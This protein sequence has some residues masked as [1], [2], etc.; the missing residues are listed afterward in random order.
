MVREPIKSIEARL[1]PRQF[2]RAHRSVVVN[3]SRVRELEPL[4]GGE[5]LIILT[6]DTRLTL[7][8]SYRDQFRTRLLN[9]S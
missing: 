4:A 2:A 8:R 6:N 9:E 1:S 7:S 5:Y 3:L